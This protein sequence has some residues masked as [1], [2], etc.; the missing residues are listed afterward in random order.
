[1]HNYEKLK[2]YQVKNDVVSSIT[3]HE[4][5]Y[6]G[7]SYIAWGYWN[8]TLLSTSLNFFP[9]HTPKLNEPIND[10]FVIR[11]LKILSTEMFYW[12]F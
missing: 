12:L 10:I 1:M 4:V 9:L 6:Q 7:R 3:M 2:T 11:M 8:V 5:N